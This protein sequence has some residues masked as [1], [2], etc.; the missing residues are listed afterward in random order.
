MS[1]PTFTIEQ[2]L[3]NIPRLESNGSN[4]AIFLIRFRGAMQAS[5]RLGYFDGS[6]TRP[7]PVTKGK[8]TDDEKKAMVRW[9]HEDHL[10]RYLLSQRL[11]NTTAVRLSS[12]NTAKECWD[13]VSDEY[14]AKIAYARNDLEQAFLKMRCT[15]G[16]DV[17]T[18]LTTLRYKHKELAVVGITITDRDYQRTVLR[19]IPDGLATFASLLLSSA[20]LFNSPATIDTDSLID[21]IC[22][23]ADRRKSR[24]TRDQPGKGGKREGQ[25]DEALA[26]T[27]SGSGRRGRRRKGKCHNCGKV[28]HW[29]RECRSP[30]EEGN[31]GQTGQ[32]SS[33]TTIK[34]ENKPISSA[35]PV[36]YDEGDGSWLAIEEEEVF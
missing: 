26:A 13:T 32:A 29:S 15:K 18:F 21:Y 9:D 31:N 10:A 11:P 24:R 3:D 17:R 6:V 14:K 7:E 22:E 19:G 33:G 35:N 28:G 36:V 5:R 34:P 2:L 4:W 8:P 30:K 25:Q 1:T 16:T 23:E 12:I 20:R 27:S